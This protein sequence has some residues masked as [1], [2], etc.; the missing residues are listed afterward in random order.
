M[1]KYSL[2]TDN[3][4]TIIHTVKGSYADVF[5]RE[6]GIT[7]QYDYQNT[8]NKNR[9]CWNR[10]SENTDPN[11]TLSSFSDDM[12]DLSIQ[13]SDMEKQKLSNHER[14]ILDETMNTF[15]EIGAEFNA[16]KTVFDNYGEYLRQKEEREK[17]EAEEKAR[18]KADALAAG[19]SEKDIVN[20]YITLTNE[21]KIGKLH[22]DEDDFLDTYAEDFPALS[23]E[24]IIKMRNDILEEMDDEALCSYYGESFRQRSVEDRF[25]VATLA[26]NNIYPEPDIQKCCEYAIENT[27]EWFSPD[28][29]EEVRK[30]MDAENESNRRYL[31]DQ[32]R[33]TEPKW[34]KFITSKEMLHL[35]LTEKNPNDSDL[36]STCSMFQDVEGKTL[37]TV[38]LIQNSIIFMSTNVQDS[39]PW[40]WGVSVREIW[41][42][43][44]KNEIKDNRETVYDGNNIARQAMER[45]RAIYPDQSAKADGRIASNNTNKSEANKSGLSSSVTQ[46]QQKTV[47]PESDKP[48]KKEGCYIATAVYGSYDAPQVMTLRRFRDETLSK[49][50]FGRWFIR[51][52]YRYSPFVAEWLKEAGRINRAVRKLLD[53]LVDRLNSK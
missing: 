50:V 47:K 39:F 49:T 3:A 38:K 41:E 37:I 46:K 29:Y 13:I 52:Y 12:N 8:E 10:V 35:I 4:N 25:T 42:A 43:A 16:G 21:R 26:L 1:D 15:N 53:R 24:E 48:K 23:D 7:V 28:E 5:A 31:D 33:S 11:E 22:R 6:K 40:Y 45:I 51:T 17:A 34:M 18:K 9:T 36:L 30:L 2:N 44:Y 14:K 20:M 32:L 19:K 27:K